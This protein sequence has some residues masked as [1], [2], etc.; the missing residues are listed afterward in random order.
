MFSTLF[1]LVS[2]AQ[3]S[4]WTSC[5]SQAAFEVKDA[6]LQPAHIY[7]GNTARFT[8]DAVNGGAEDIA[9]GKITMLVRYVV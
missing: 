1:L 9:A 7:P 3:A 6:L 5:A 4:S 8:I 2:A